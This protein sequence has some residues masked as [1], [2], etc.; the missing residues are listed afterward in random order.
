M[1]KEKKWKGRRKKG[2][3][4]GMEERRGKREREG[5]NRE[6]RHGERGRGRMKERRAV[7]KR[8]RNSSRN[9]CN[10]SEDA[11]H[12]C[13]PGLYTAVWAC[14]ALT[15]VQAPP[16]QFI[17]ASHSTSISVGQTW[18]QC[19]KTGLLHLTWPPNPGQLFQLVF[20]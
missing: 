8:G 1:K 11:S 4:E 7:G 5:R 9:H 15:N 20:N 10:S 18:F 17:C 2:K 19:L 3:K 14:T 13:T 16:S 12:C 6:G